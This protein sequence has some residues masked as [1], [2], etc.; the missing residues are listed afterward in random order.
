MAKSLSFLSFMLHI[1]VTGTVLGYK[2]DPSCGRKGME[3]DVRAAMT[4]AFEMVDAAGRR[5]DEKPLNQNT[6]GIMRYLFAQPSQDPTTLDMTKTR[7]VL[8]RIK[9]TYGT[10][11]PFDGVAN[12]KDVVSM[13]FHIYRHP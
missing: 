8:S 6:I 13:S 10:E 2:I 5:L 12:I 7:R 3:N 11:I 1:I 4:S 9:E